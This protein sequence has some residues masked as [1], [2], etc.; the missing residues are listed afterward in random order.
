MRKNWTSLFAIALALSTASG[1]SRFQIKDQI[2]YG[3]KGKF[4]ATAVHTIR[5]DIKP[6][7]I[8]KAQ[9]DQIRIGMVCGDAAYIGYMLTLVDKLCAQLKRCDYEDV[10]RVKA[11]LRYVASAAKLNRPLSFFV[12]D[13]PVCI[14]G[15]ARELDP[16]DFEIAHSLGTDQEV[17]EHNAIE[18]PRLEPEPLDFAN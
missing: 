3:D 18:A 7:A 2:L 10:A 12:D 16:R 6:V 13:S 15:D 11:A 4:G 17:L 9:W 14:Q 1:C 5:K 8:P